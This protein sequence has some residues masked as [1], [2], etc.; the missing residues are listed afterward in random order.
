MGTCGGCGIGG[1]RYSGTGGG[2]AV[3][4]RKAIGDYGW[5]NGWLFSRSFSR[6]E[7]STQNH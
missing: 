2:C 5:D 7:K 3:M 4:I 1:G 6:F